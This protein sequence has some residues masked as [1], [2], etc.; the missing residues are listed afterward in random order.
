[1]TRKLRRTHTDDPSVRPISV[2]ERRRLQK[3][4]Q[5]QYAEFRGRYREIHGKVVDWL[6][7]SFEEGTLYISIRFDDKTELALEFRH[8]IV[9]DGIDL[10]DIRTGEAKV[11]RE[12]HKRPDQ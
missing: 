4:L 3:R 2:K 9:I 8:Q 10:A 12:Y 7:C 11:L 5:K 6:H 1:M